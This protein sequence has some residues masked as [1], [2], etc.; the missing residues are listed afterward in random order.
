MI[1]TG[2]A[3][4]LSFSVNSRPRMSV[5]LT[6]FIKPGKIVYTDALASWPEGADDCPLGA[7]CNRST[8]MY[9]DALS[10]PGKCLNR[11][12]A[13]S[14]NTALRWPVGYFETGKLMKKSE[15]FLESKPRSALSKLM[16][17]RTNKPVTLTSITV[18]VIS[19]MTNTFRIRRTLTP[20][21]A[22]GAPSLRELVTSRLRDLSAR[23]PPNTTPQIKETNMQN[24]TVRPFKA[25]CL[26]PGFE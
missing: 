21:L 7:N 23:L 16:K 26:V 25:I 2:G 20:V 15:T 17:D 5:A 4:A 11:S 22:A 8:G 24:A 14:K 13:D 1:P 3:P 18:N 19:P 6:V 12:S 9:A 10:T